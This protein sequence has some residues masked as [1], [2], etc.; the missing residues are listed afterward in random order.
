MITIKNAPS[1]QSKMAIQGHV[2]GVSGKPTRDYILLYNNVGLIFEG[3]KDTATESIKNHH[4]WP[5]KV[6]CYA[7]SPQKPHKYLH[8]PYIAGNYSLSCWQ[9][10]S[11]FIQTSTVD[12]KRC[13]F[14][15]RD[16]SSIVTLV[17][18]VPLQI[19]SHFRDI[20]GFLLKTA[21]HHYS[22]RILGVFPL[23]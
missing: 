23:N 14:W 2:F 15:N 10:G 7:P 6:S 13:M 17:H 21:T 11:I 3:S 20:A 18:L 19:L 1:S 4:F 12:S 8:K 9:Y 16:W 22:T 5:P